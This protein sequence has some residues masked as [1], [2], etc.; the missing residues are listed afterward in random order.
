MK[1]LR[2]R[3]FTRLAP[4]L[5]ATS[6]LGSVAH[7]S[8]DSDA[9]ADESGPVRFLATA[10]PQYGP[11]DDESDTATE[12]LASAGYALAVNDTLRGLIVAGDLTDRTRLDEFQK[13]EN[14]IADI[15]DRVYDGIGNHD[16]DDQYPC[17]RYYFCRIPGMIREH[18]KRDRADVVNRG[19]GGESLHYSWDWGGVHFVQL[20][21]YPA[22]FD[23]TEEDK[24]EFN[25]DPEG[26]LD[27][28]E[29]DLA[30]L[31]GGT[32]TPVVLVHHY[33]PDGRHY[34][35]EGVREWSEKRELLYWNAIADY[36]V[37][38][39]IHGH[40]HLDEGN[41]GRWVQ[42]WRRPANSTVG[43]DSIHMINVGAAKYGMFSRIE[44]DPDA[45]TIRLLRH[46]AD[47]RFLFQTQCADGSGW[48]VQYRVLNFPAR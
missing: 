2:K 14:A 1:T 20:N 11:N 18:I 38:A 10:D 22:R 45:E 34:N 35:K 4:V 26:S 46:G 41:T 21:H 42:Q 16:L 30:A 33:Q 44:I 23:P 28:L 25:V 29:A 39:V 6:L 8:P 37:V 15:I 13:Y 32:Q 40:A 12:A 27:F 9:A 19:S 47:G 17:D 3:I 43:P 31:P 7:A 24:T 5:C 48:C 36:N